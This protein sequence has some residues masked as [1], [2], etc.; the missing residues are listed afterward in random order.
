MHELSIANAIVS[1]ARDRAASRRVLAVDVRVGRLRQVVPDALALAF[2][3]AATGTSVA[4]AKLN[5]ESVPVRV[6]CGHCGSES[7]QNEFPLICESCGSLDVEVVA[8]E[9]LLVES[10]ELE[11]VLIP[12]KQSTPVG[13]M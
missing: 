6:A 10:L 1:I 7:E 8:G 4:G 11:D 3:V 9:E 2:D 13:G 12:E 5:I